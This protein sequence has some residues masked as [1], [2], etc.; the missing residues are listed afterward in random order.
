MSGS[1]EGGV[2]GRDACCERVCVQTG[3]LQEVPPQFLN[4]VF[5]GMK[6]Q[7][8]P[9]GGKV[10]GKECVDIR[11]CLRQSERQQRSTQLQ[12]PDSK[13]GFSVKEESRTSLFSMRVSSLDA[14]KTGCNAP[15]SS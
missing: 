14:V 11:V 10:S 5:V 7:Q 2:G 15:L 1:G 6:K 9:K 3:F 12:M 4:G 8:E 13:L